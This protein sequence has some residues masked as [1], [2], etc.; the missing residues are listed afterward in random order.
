[1]AT[2]I[3]A[4]TGAT[5]LDGVTEAQFDR[6]YDH[7]SDWRQVRSRE[8]VNPEHR[9]RFDTRRQR[10]IGDTEHWLIED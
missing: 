5:V 10:S 2:V 9:E 1:M 6:W 4:A 7:H 8:E 3:N